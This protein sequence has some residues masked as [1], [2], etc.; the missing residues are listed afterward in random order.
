MKR[1]DVA[2]RASCW[3]ARFM[4]AA[5]ILF[6]LV[7]LAAEAAAGCTSGGG[8]T[9][10]PADA[11]GTMGAPADASVTI[12]APASFD[13][14][15]EAY[16]G[17]CTFAPMRTICPARPTRTALQWLPATTAARRSAAAFRSASARAR[18]PSSTRTWARRRSAPDKWREPM[19]VYRGVG[20]VLLERD[21][22]GRRWLIRR[23]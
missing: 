23:C 4:R 22:P 13:S 2:W 20:P 21:M 11:S 5:G 3:D 8:A 18:W 10:V 1:E 19:R 16:T 15:L 7:C 6:P 9:S 12:D 17:P 14:A